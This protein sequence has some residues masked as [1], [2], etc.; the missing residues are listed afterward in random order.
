MDTFPDRPLVGL[1]I[2]LIIL[3]IFVAFISSTLIVL[4]SFVSHPVI[5]LLLICIANSCVNSFPDTSLLSMIITGP[6]CIGCGSIAALSLCDSASSLSAKR[7]KVFLMY[8]PSVWS[9]THSQFPLTCSS[10][11]TFSSLFPTLYSVHVMCFLL[12]HCF[13][14]P[15]YDMFWEFP[16][17]HADVLSWTLSMTYP[18]VYI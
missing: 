13:G 9:L 6:P 4:S 15:F 3:H 7:F 12:F 10:L 8:F 2:F 5:L 14:L 17:P 18:N 1:L 16:C 11:I